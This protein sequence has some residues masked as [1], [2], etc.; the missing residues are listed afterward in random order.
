[1]D[2]RHLTEK[3]LAELPP[4]PAGK[5]RET[6]DVKVHRLAVRVTTAGEKSFVLYAR[7]PRRPETPTRRRLGRWPEMKLDGARQK[8]R[9]W[10][11]QI[12]RG[13]DPADEEERQQREA[14]ASRANTFA[15]VADEFVRQRVV[16]VRSYDR[17][18]ALAAAHG[19]PKLPAM[20][21]LIRP[22]AIKTNMRKAAA[23][24][25]DVNVFVERWG[26]RP[27]SGITPRDVRAVL[28]EVIK[29]DARYRAFNLLTHIK[30][31][32]KFAVAHEHLIVS[33]AASLSATHE[34]G[35]ARPRDRVLNDAELGAF[36]HAATPAGYPLGPLAHVLALTGQRLSDVSGARWREF[37]LAA[38]TWVVPAERMKMATAH[39]VPLS[40]EVVAL[41]QKLPRFAGGDLLFSFSYG[42]TPPVNFNR[43]KKALDERMRAAVSDFPPF[44]LHDIRRTVR[45][46]LVGPGVGAPPHV[47]ELVIA[48]GKR[49]ISRVYDL[50]AYDNEKR[51]ALTAWAGELRRIVD[52]T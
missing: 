31:V 10:L 48:H 8:A 22:N 39:A 40:D 37:D 41:L 7:F 29:R 47:A 5:R 19:G 21:R 30:M 3:L 20:A 6:F 33:P 36:W 51:A 13:I 32:L 45:T 50:H 16:G 43:F 12:E 11:D 28:A 52:G 24:I 23:L 4:A 15:A 9:Q 18:A 35:R 34:I 1:M 2:R 27:I 26:R 42:A 38:K 49:G 25:R 44:V 14:A 46:R 17:L